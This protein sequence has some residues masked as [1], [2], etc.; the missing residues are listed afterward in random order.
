MT[1][2][3]LFVCLLITKSKVKKT[4]PGIQSTAISGTIYSVGNGAL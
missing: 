2:T 3:A 1:I 4:M